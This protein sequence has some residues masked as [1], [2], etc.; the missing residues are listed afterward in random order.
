MPLPD[1]QK[2]FGKH[3]VDF[4]WPQTGLVVE[5]DGARFHATAAQ[6]TADRKRDQAHIRAGRTPLRVTH[7]QVVK[8]PAETTTLLADVFT[9]RQCRPGSASSKRAA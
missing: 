2:R 9:A 4:H 7:W 3:R 1:T 5:A 8:E 6:Q